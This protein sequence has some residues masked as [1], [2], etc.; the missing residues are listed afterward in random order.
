[1]R[2]LTNARLPFVL[3]LL[4][5]PAV[6]AA[7]GEVDGPVDANPVADAPV[8]AEAPAAEEPVVVNLRTTPASDGPIEV[9]I[10]FH[11]IRITDVDE[12]EETLDF[13][14]GLH[15]L[16]HDPRLAYDPVDIGRPDYEH[17]PG[18]FSRKP[19]LIFQGDFAVKE[20]FDGW[21]PHVRINNG[22]GDRQISYMAIAIW[23]DGHIAYTDQFHATAETPMA[24]R[25]F[26]FDTQHLELFIS[27]YAFKRHE[28][29]FVHVPG[30]V[31]SWSQD[32]GIAD[33]ERIGLDIEEQPTEI[34][35]LDGSA[36][37]LSEL[38]VTV[39]LRRRPGHI[40]FSII[41]PLLILVS[42]SWSVFWMDDESI[43]DRVNVSF[44]G[45]LSVVAY[46]FVILD[47]VPQIPYPTMMDAFMITTFITL[48]SSVVVNFVVDKLNRTGRGEA[49]DRVDRTCR[50]A[51]PLGYTLVTAAVVAVFS[52]V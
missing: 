42:L 11:L 43:S 30:L 41:F 2:V 6:A 7:Q 51:F 1:M 29:V 49:G 8:A 18:D 3:L 45:I 50:W 4:A 47:T 37:T 34:E 27:P 24:L 9:R 16:W 19:P 36:T 17:V 5:A 25:R 46:Y 40:L 13:E 15:M 12:R 28:M 21:R 44:V 33:W 48:A 39:S 52:S 38:I 22:I 26:P 31:G 20:V 32:A 35:M 23:P 10:G 14:G